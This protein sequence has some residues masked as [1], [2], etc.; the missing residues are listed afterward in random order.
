LLEVF[1][2]PELG[3]KLWEALAVVARAHGSAHVD[4]VL[5]AWG[6][7]PDRMQW[8]GGVADLCAGLV[9]TRE[10]AAVAA[11]FVAGQ[12][13]GWTSAGQV[14]GPRLRGLRGLRLRV[15][16]DE[17]DDDVVGESDGGDVAQTLVAML[18]A[19]AMV[20]RVDLQDE[21]VAWLRAREEPV[22]RLAIAVLRAADR[23]APALEGD[24]IEALASACFARLEQ[25][26]D[27]PVREASDWSIGW[28]DG[29]GCDL[30]ERLAEF[31]EDDVTR[32]MEWPL[33]KDRR[34]HVHGKIDAADLPVSHATRRSGSPHV[35]VLEKTQALFEREEGERRWCEAQVRWLRARGGGAIRSARERSGGVRGRVDDAAVGVVG[36]SARCR[37]TRRSCAL[38]RLSRPSMWRCRFSSRSVR[39][40]ASTADRGQGYASTAHDPASSR[41]TGA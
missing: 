11:A 37:R 22:P 35:L 17:L 19:S 4:A 20:G 41:G 18:R 24:A 13:R 40:Q 36:A 2:A 27:V 30:C 3:T 26:L 21:I 8:L 38:S 10:G 9:T 7:H 32:R 23:A 12:W 39:A 16:E 29:C 34:R 31:L 33:A 15:I 28:D 1:D 14:R 6:R 5:E 25:R